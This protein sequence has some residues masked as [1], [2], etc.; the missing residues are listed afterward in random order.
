M[1]TPRLA[2]SKAVPG[3]LRQNGRRVRTTSAIGDAIAPNRAIEFT[4]TLLELDFYE[5]SKPR[6]VVMKVAADTLA[7][8]K[9]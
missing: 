5:E 3:R 6:K 2:A 7:P 4:G 8:I 9:D 1:V